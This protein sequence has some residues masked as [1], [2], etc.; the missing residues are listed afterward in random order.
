M[1]EAGGTST[2]MDDSL[3]VSSSRCRALN[4][5]VPNEVSSSS[6]ETPPTLD[7]RR[8][9]DP[10][11][12]SPVSRSSSSAPPRRDKPGREQRQPCSR[13]M[14]VVPR[15]SFPRHGNGADTTGQANASKNAALSCPRMATV[16]RRLLRFT[17]TS[18]ATRESSLYCILAVPRDGSSAALFRALPFHP[19]FPPP[20]AATLPLS[21]HA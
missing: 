5:R 7:P 15:T 12:P 2:K 18:R 6:Y 10:P 9:S 8:R 21:R 1:G 11:D 20:P 19:V 3:P 16:R 17:G 14:Q 13:H 4:C